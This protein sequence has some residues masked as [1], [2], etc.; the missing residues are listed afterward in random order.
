MLLS[1]K[2]GYTLSGRYNNSTK[3]NKIQTVTVLRINEVNW[4]NYLDGNGNNYN[5]LL[6]DDLFK[7][8]ELDHIGIK[9]KEANAESMEVLK[10]FENTIEFSEVEQ[11][12]FVMLPWKQDKRNLPSNYALAVGRLR[13]L[14][15][16]FLE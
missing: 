8:V 16:I 12:Y 2:V 14:Q 15:N 6:K 5:V 7:L 11:P 9:P 1:T 4:D 3:V 13:Q 10:H